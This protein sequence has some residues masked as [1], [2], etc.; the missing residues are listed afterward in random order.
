MEPNI[1]KKTMFLMFRKK[2]ALLGGSMFVNSGVPPIFRSVRPP[3]A[4]TPLRTQGRSHV[5]P[6]APSPAL[7]QPTSN[8]VRALRS[9][10]VTRPDMCRLDLSPNQG[11]RLRDS[12]SLPH[13]RYQPDDKR[14]VG[15]MEHHQSSPHQLKKSNKVLKSR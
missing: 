9:R 1:Q 10:L 11:L 8:C 15:P 7:S 6:R 4:T 5:G 14:A 12:L 2:M 13:S 3:L